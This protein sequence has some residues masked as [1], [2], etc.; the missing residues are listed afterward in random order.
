MDDVGL[1][2]DELLEETMRRLVAEVVG[3]ESPPH[4]WEMLPRLLAIAQ[5][6]CASGDQP[7]C[8]LVRGWVW[9]G[10]AAVLQDAMDR[11]LTT[12]IEHYGAAREE[13]L[14]PEASVTPQ[15]CDVTGASLARCFAALP[16]GLPGHLA[17]ADL[18]RVQRIYEAQSVRAQAD[19][20]ILEL[21][22]QAFAAY[23]SAENAGE[24]LRLAG[25]LDE[26][27]SRIGQISEPDA[28]G[29]RWL[30]GH[31]ERSIAEGTFIPAPG[32]R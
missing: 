30:I 3:P 18:G 14:I 22:N 31:V 16:V 4:D 20:D 28:V 5:H 29:M 12:D 11:H 19:L 21:I 26:Y 27:Q 15:A 9:D 2:L 23:P 8:I 32:T 1:T 25:L 10:A 7:M 17:M 6:H 24:A 13:F